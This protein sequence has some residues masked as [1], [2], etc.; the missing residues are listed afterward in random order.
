M[1]NLILACVGLA[2]AIAGGVYLCRL[3]YLKKY[4]VTT[5]AEV[6]GVREAPQRK[7][8]S[9]GAYIHTMRY[10]VSGKTY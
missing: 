8:K 6:L 4:G 2:I 7:G 5:K 9:A 10:T 1:G 3:L